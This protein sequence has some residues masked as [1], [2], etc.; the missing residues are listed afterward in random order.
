MDLYYKKKKQ[1]NFND[2]NFQL[3]DRITAIHFI[4]LL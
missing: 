4:Y 1:F 2:L 3:Y